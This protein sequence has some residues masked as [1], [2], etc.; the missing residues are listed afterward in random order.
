MMQRIY[1]TK[2]EGPKLTTTRKAPIESGFTSRAHRPKPDS[3]GQSAYCHPYS[4]GLFLDPSTD[5]A[6]HEM[7]GM[8]SLAK[9]FLIFIFRLLTNCRIANSP[10]NG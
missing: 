3:P 9:V 1:L 8:S 7:P 6:P 5:R 2:Y 10:R 4:Q